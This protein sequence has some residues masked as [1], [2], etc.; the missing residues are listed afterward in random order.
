MVF[1]SSCDD[2]V[3]VD[4]F[5][6]RTFRKRS[7]WL[8]TSR[9]DRLLMSTPRGRGVLAVPVAEDSTVAATTCSLQ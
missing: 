3:E 8:L 5:N 9:A 6:D 1:G 7:D 4:D 2:E